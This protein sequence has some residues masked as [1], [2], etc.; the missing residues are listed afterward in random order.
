[1][2]NGETPA[3]STF[4]QEYFSRME[5][6]QAALDGRHRRQQRLN[7]F[8]TFGSVCGI[9]ALAVVLAA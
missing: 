5:K 4:W 7:A 9:I 6:A 1:M 3:R 2:T 8:H